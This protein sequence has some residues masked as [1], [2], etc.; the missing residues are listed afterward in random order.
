MER[1]EA[2]EEMDIRQ[3]LKISILRYSQTRKSLHDKLFGDINFELCGDTAIINV[4][5][6]QVIYDFDRTCNDMCKA[7]SIFDNMS[8]YTQIVIHC[9]YFSTYRGNDLEGTPT[10]DEIREI[11]DESIAHKFICSISEHARMY[12]RYEENN[13]ALLSFTCR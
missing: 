5:A 6:E 8:F 4:Y 12:G 7:L 9:V 3:A 10:C 13:T 1:N 2:P 11:L